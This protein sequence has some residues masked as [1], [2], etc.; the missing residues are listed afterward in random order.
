MKEDSNLETS[1]GWIEE[2]RGIEHSWYSSN[3]DLLI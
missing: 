3:T 1:L 2:E